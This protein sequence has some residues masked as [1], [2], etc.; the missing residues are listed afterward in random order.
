MGPCETAREAGNPRNQRS[1]RLGLLHRRRHLHRNLPSVSFRMGR[2]TWT[3]CFREKIGSHPGERLHSMS[4]VR[5]TMPNSGNQD[6]STVNRTRHRQY[7]SFLSFRLCSFGEIEV[8]H[9]RIGLVKDK[10]G[11]RQFCG[12]RVCLSLGGFGSGLSSVRT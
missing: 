3:S 5:D 4:G 10:S 2:H 1:R 7:L 9:F 8:F 11:F 6:Y 12:D